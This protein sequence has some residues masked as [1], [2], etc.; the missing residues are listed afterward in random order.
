VSIRLSGRGHA[1]PDN[2]I[3]GGDTLPAELLWGCTGLAFLTVVKGGFFF[4]G[5]CGTGCVVAKL[6]D[7]R[8]GHRWSAPSAICLLNVGWGFQVGGEVTDIMFVLNS[9]E[10]SRLSQ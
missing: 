9:R 7:G 3:E 1:Q 6:P 10:V 2:E 4:S 8:G 5:T